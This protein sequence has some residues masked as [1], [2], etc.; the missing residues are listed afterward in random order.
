LSTRR[1]AA[2]LGGGSVRIQARS[3]R[4]VGVIAVLMAVA[5]CES[6]AS[7]GDVDALEGIDASDEPAP[8]SAP[9]RQI[10]EAAPVVRSP[11][12]R[13]L[14][15]FAAEVAARRAAVQR[16]RTP[17]PPDLTSA[18][19]PPAVFDVAGLDA[20]IHKIV[21]PLERST[22]ISVHIRELASDD[23]LFDYRGD[24]PLNPASNHKMLLST[25]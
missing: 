14:K 13:R 7:I 12:A 25:S 16:A 3:S 17:E 2:M 1:R 22:D 4:S 5:A 10:P 24:A 15:V 11:L 18:A 21:A 8:A 9:A 6:P 23:I 19:G 20:A